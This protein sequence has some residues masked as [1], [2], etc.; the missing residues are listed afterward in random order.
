MLVRPECALASERAGCAGVE[1]RLPQRWSGPSDGAPRRVDDWC[2]RRSEAGTTAMSE[3]H[4]RWSSERQH[5]WSIDADSHTSA[6]RMA[7]PQ[8]A[9]RA[10]CGTELSLR[11][12]GGG[13]CHRPPR[14]PKWHS[15]L[16]EPLGVRYMEQHQA[17]A[18]KHL[19]ALVAY[20]QLSLAAFCW[21]CAPGRCHH[22]GPPLAHVRY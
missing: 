15:G 18:V 16:C 8:N 1:P 22:G 20:S 13:V 6:A 4:P 9:R 11:L 17:L 7:L 12:L 10:F 21:C 5:S 2:S 14:T 19:P 3:E